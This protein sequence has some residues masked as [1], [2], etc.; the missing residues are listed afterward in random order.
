MSVNDNAH[1][2]FFQALIWAL[3]LPLPERHLRV[4]LALLSFMEGESRRAWPSLKRLTERVVMMKPDTVHMTMAELI[5]CGLLTKVHTDNK[6]IPKKS[7]VRIEV[8]E[9]LAPDSNPLSSILLQEVVRRIEDVTHVERWVLLAMARN[10]DWAIA[11]SVIDYKR[12]RSEY[13]WLSRQQWRAALR[14]LVER[15]VISNVR[16]GNRYSMPYYSL[17]GLAFYIGHRDASSASSDVTVTHLDPQMSHRDATRQSYLRHR[18]ASSEDESPIYVRAELPIEQVVVVED[19]DTT[20][21]TGSSAVA[22]TAEFEAAL[23]QNVIPQ[24]GEKYIPGQHDGQEHRLNPVRRLIRQYAWEGQTTVHPTQAARLRDFIESADWITQRWGHVG[25]IKDLVE[26]WVETGEDLSRPW[27]P[28]PDPEATAPADYIDL[29]DIRADP[30]AQRIWDDAL[31]QL[32]LHVTRPNF[33]TWLKRTIGLE[34]GDGYFIVG[35]PNTFVAEMLEQRM[36]S[37]LSRTIESIVKQEVNVRFTV[38]LDSAEQE[39]LRSLT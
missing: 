20:T 24:R 14:R 19:R 32:Q 30:E 34:T 17:P 18:D 9:T 1:P 6:G 10:Y 29:V 12:A 16:R 11:A 2:N 31:G 4:L 27:E 7:A 26:M 36:Y 38:Y 22:L 33:E 23:I 25:A 5:E 15:G 21:T 3:S 13:P 39:Q 28:P 8:G 35:T 37:L